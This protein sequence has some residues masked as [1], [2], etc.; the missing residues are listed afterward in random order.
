MSD[1]ISRFEKLI[2]RITIIYGLLYP[3]VAA[4]VCALI[5][6]IW[7]PNYFQPYSLPIYAAIVFGITVVALIHII[8]IDTLS[9]SQ[10]AFIY[11]AY[12][13]M[14]LILTLFVSPYLSPFA[15]LWIV[16]TV[17]VDINFGRR[18]MFAVLGLYLLAIAA[19]FV[20]TA[21]DMSVAIFALSLAQITGVVFISLQVSK[22][23]QVSDEERHL[24]ADTVRSSAYEHQRLLS[25]I[26]SMGD[27]V[28]ATSHD[29]KI[30]LY[31]AAVLDLLDTNATLDRKTLD[32]VLNI[33]DKEGKK[34]HLLK[35]VA[36]SNL[37]LTTTDY[38]HQF[39][40]NDV[41]NLYINISPI[42]L[43]F[44]EEVES[45]YIVILRD[46]TKEKSLE[47]ERDEFI[48]V[49]SHELRT[50]IAIA[51]GDIS[52]AL[53]VTEKNHDPK[54][55]TGSLKQA[56]E[57]VIFLAN[58][59]NDLA[60]LSRA[61]RTDVVLELTKI[62]LHDFVNTLIKDYAPDA[63]KKKLSLT[64]S[65]AAGVKP[66]ITSELYLREILQNFIT[67]A[68]KY[69][70]AGSVIIHVRTNKH[71]EAVFS[72]ADSGIG[73][74]KADQKKVFEKFFRSEDY[75]T[76]ESNGTGLGLY[77]TS[78]LAHRLQAQITLESELNKGT[79]FT[80][81]VPSLK[82]TKTV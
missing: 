34:V 75:R 37:G 61:E 55:V 80:I 31:N 64:G 76:R 56:H 47:E 6:W 77:V 24:V 9:R 5:L 49:I 26:N 65:V 74:S 59:I 8:R 32:S 7:V 11:I 41:I 45:G 17:G 21:Q 4:N 12:C 43:G 79:T 54:V 30:L 69:T 71:G 20:Y 22:Y 28:I 14:M 15:F 25:L 13:L 19:S 18:W 73:L 62:D 39:E 51:E 66:L 78:K 2:N 50:P 68:V 35:L 10:F 42:K 81:T 46:I 33:R 70:K 57:H 1:V 53:F 48:S 3:I 82:E 63:A 44:K 72:V 16:L 67:N 38:I 60:T 58:M 52:N 36:K 23:R 27:A 29:G 40:L